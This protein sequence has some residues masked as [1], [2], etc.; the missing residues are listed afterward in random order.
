MKKVLLIT[1]LILGISGCEKKN[2]TEP[3]DVP[4]EKKEEIVYNLNENIMVSEEYDA[5]LCG[6]SMFIT[7]A[8][9]LFPQA[10]IDNN[11]ISYWPGDAKEAEASEISE[12]Q[13]T[14]NFDKMKFEISKEVNAK[15]LMGSIKMNLKTTTGIKDFEYEFDKHRFKYSYYYLNFKDEKYTSDGLGINQKIKESFKDAITF[16][17]PCGNAQSEYK[18]LTEE[19]CNEYNLKCK[20]IS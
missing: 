7:N 4:S 17:G 19:L 8:K 12:A 1:L 2:A 16:A 9:E 13:L 10:K 15:G 11:V 14:E 3:E 6:F 5:T 20:K 18:V